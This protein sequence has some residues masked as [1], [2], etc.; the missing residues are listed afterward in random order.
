[1]ANSSSFVDSVPTCSGDPSEF[2]TFVTACKWYVKGL[3]SSEQSQ[4]ASRVWSRLKGP[5]KA[6][7]RHL[8]PAD[9]SDEQGLHRLLEV[10]WMSPLQQLPVPDVFRPL[11]QWHQLKRLSS[12]TIPELLVREEDLFLQ[13]QQSLVR[14][15]EGRFP[16][17]SG[18][19]GTPEPSINRPPSTP[20]QSPLG[21]RHSSVPD[22]SARRTWAPRPQESKEPETRDLFEDE[23]RGY[24]LLKSARLTTSER[25]SVLTQTNNSTGFLQIRWALRTLFSEDDYFGKGGLRKGRLYWNEYEAHGEDEDESWMWEAD[26]PGTW[27]WDDSQYSHWQSWT[28]DSWYQQQDSFV[29]EGAWDE[30][31]LNDTA[32]ADDNSDPVEQ[33]F[34]EA[35]ALAGEANKTLAEAREAVR[36]V[37]QARGYFAPESM[38]GKGIS[39]SPS[40]SP[41]RGSSGVFSKGNHLVRARRG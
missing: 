34:R 10:L 5:A 14:A 15:R 11:D 7:V 12:E 3:I 9:Y 23:L 6:V 37:R 26:D 32:N 21:A 17:S 39:G 19:F 8:N 16:G 27:D 30:E 35:Y 25:Q 20:S 18:A 38:S 40:S 22:D 33:Q 24:R 36:K 2:E 4:A 13:L 29:D 41:H 1:M 31:L 28:D